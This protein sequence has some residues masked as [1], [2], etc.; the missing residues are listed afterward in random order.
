MVILV[1]VAV[2]VA[3]VIV[4][5]RVITLRAVMVVAVAKVIVDNPMQRVVVT[6]V[7]MCVVGP[8]KP[9]NVRKGGSPWMLRMSMV[10]VEAVWPQ[11]YDLLTLCRKHRQL[12]ARK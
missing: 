4:S 8:I 1:V 6:K 10:A 7:A 11:Q 12:V 5:R 9:G 2:V 3:K